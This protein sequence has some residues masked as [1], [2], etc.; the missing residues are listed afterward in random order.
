MNNEKVSRKHC[1]MDLR[2]LLRHC[3]YVA[4]GLGA[5]FEAESCTGGRLATGRSNLD[6]QL[7]AGR[8]VSRR[9]GGKAL[10]SSTKLPREEF[11]EVKSRVLKASHPHTRNLND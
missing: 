11:P 10:L 5:P 1:T 9:A 4:E 7:K 8:K 6:G 2:P 3:L